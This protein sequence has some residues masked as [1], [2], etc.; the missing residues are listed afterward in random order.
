MPAQ[1]STSLSGAG[2]W[3]AT[4]ASRTTSRE[5]PKRRH[6]VDAP[7]LP[8]ISNPA[9]N[10]I[11]PTSIHSPPHNGTSI[12]PSEVHAPAAAHQSR[13]P[14][15]RPANTTA[16]HRS[17]PPVPRRQPARP[18]APPPV[19]PSAALSPP[20]RSPA[21]PAPPS[22]A[23]RPPT[24]RRSSP[25]S[26]PAARAPRAP[27]AP[28][29]PCCACTRTSRPASRSTRWLC[30]CCRWCLSLALWRFTVCFFFLLVF[31]ARV[32]RVDW[33]MGGL[34]V[35]LGDWKL[36][37]VQ[38]SSPSSRAASRAKYISSVIHG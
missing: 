12:L 34:G 14:F 26:G 21:A 5:T 15:P 27:A 1:G 35:L 10:P 32:W 23:A 33:M 37:R 11:T 30:W 9:I 20:P 22:V 18:R 28:A 24:R 38:Q 16:R 2:L 8:P 31:G 3:T 17:L 6:L 4:P 7:F 36:T 13:A 19:P 25:T 29:A